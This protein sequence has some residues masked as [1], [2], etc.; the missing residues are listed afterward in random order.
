MANK[1]TTKQIALLKKLNRYY[2][3]ELLEVLTIKTASKLIAIH[4]KFRKVPHRY[5]NYLID[6]QCDLECE[7]FG[8][9]ITHDNDF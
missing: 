7:I 3:D 4:L 2:T 8:K 1:A 6:E 9:I 5:H